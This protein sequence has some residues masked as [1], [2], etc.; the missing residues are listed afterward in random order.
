MSLIFYEGSALSEKS[1]EMYRYLLKKAEDNPEKR[2][3]LIVPDQV[4][5]TAQGALIRMSSHHALTNLEVLSFNRF[6]YR[7]F[8]EQQIEVR[9]LLDEAGKELLIR[10]ISESQKENLKKFRNISTKWGMVQ[11]IKSILSELTQ[12]NISPDVLKEKCNELKKNTG[13]SLL[14]TKLEDICVYYEA[15]LPLLNQNYEI[16]EDRMKRLA[17]SLPN[18]QGISE[19]T[20][21]FDDFT[22]FTPLQ[23]EVLRVL[24]PLASEVIIGCTVGS[25][26]DLSS[27]KEKTSLFY[28]SHIFKEKCQSYAIE[29]SVPIE[30]RH[31][32]AKRSVSPETEHIETSLYRHP[33]VTYDE[34]SNI[35]IYTGRTKKEEVALVV[36]KIRDAVRKGVKYREM[37]V[38][39]G[40]AEEYRAE[41][42]AEAE[43]SEIP[44][45]IDS[46]KLLTEHPAPLLLA[47][48][49]SLAEKDCT[50]ETIIPFLKNPILIHYL[51]KKFPY[52]ENG[53]LDMYEQICR[54]E[55]YLYVSGKRGIHQYSEPWIFKI[56]ALHF[57]DSDMDSLNALRQEI[58]TLLEPFVKTIRA[59]NT[60]NDK[61]NACRKLL[62][63]CKVDDYSAKKAEAGESVSTEAVLEYLD[64]FLGQAES[65]LSGI[66]LDAAVFSEMISQSVLNLSVGAKPPTQDKIILGDL[67]RTRLP[68]IKK[69]F[70]MGA[71]DR[72]FPKEKD[73]SGLL[74]DEDR[75]FLRD[76]GVELSENSLTLSFFN[77]YYLYLLMTRPSEEINIS[78]LT[79]EDKKPSFFVWEMEHLFPKVRVQNISD[80]PW[81]D[82]NSF[83]SGI[84]KF[85]DEVRNL[86][87]NG[88]SPDSPYLHRAADLYYYL[89][90]GR[91]D[92]EEYNEIIESLKNVWDGLYYKYPKHYLPREIANALYES[93]KKPSISF[94]QKYAECPY[95]HFLQY[96]LNLTALR[97][98]GINAMDTGTL[99]HD[100]IDAFFRKLK[101]KNLRLE[102]LS[103]EERENLISEAIDM[104]AEDPKN[105]ILRESRRNAFI[106][107]RIESIAK[108]TVETLQFQWKC[109]EFTDTETELPFGEEEDVLKMTLSD[110]QEISFSGR[111]DRLDTLI[112]EDKVYVK[113]ID[114]KSSVQKVDFSEIFHGLKLQLFLYL[115]AVKEVLK[116]RYEGS[117]IIPVGAYYYSI[118][119]PIFKDHKPDASL[120]K[121]V[122]DELVL[123]GLTNSEGSVYPKLDRR[124]DPSNPDRSGIDT[125]G[126]VA[127]SLSLNRDNT[128]GKSALDKMVSTD[129]LDVLGKYTVKKSRDIMEEIKGGNI[130]P[131]RNLLGSGFDSCKYCPYGGVCQFNVSPGCQPKPLP[132]VGM[133]EI[134][135]SMN[136]EGGNDNA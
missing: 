110:G 112:S 56:R 98:H 102:A 70:I 52:S 103:A 37:A 12:Y 129:D 63:D 42:F 116:R 71:N 4:S 21:A 39:C 125:D 57:S 123:Q 28:M 108:R 88:L 100:S 58:Y 80:E 34:A 95:E 45:F 16:T 99:L 49:L 132:K 14:T 23:Y 22:G 78:Y 119:D 3:F 76:N 128:L 94:L 32:T 61:V 5:L 117:E 84:T 2:V 126:K 124:L 7:V 25:G 27:E 20:I 136:S 9:D 105:V 36:H 106:K 130:D 113:I 111:I 73:G 35:H 93:Y 83:S 64:R 31:I 118:K 101:E 60:V 135:N 51:A 26:I 40:D 120:E 62:M 11:E 19:M 24:I 6:A 38:V 86:Y 133:E 109:G 115:Y 68:N 30:E 53:H 89:T 69:L 85:S 127:N 91:K 46:R 90:Q 96:G 15:F 29:Q 18:W 66:T 82:V 17:S 50:E 134:K 87:T 72:I 10:Y 8:E 74:N 107:D 65:L 55:N 43:E 122:H 92:T 97:P 48:A 1:T 54:L 75:D 13:E 41:F 104:V 67:S 44:I 114:Y 79:G 59:K 131:T 121:R 77:R 81:Y 47:T 33:T